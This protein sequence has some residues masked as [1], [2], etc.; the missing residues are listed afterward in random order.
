MSNGVSSIP[1]LDDECFSA[2]GG[3]KLKTIKFVNSIEKT[4]LLF[5][6]IKKHISK[7]LICFLP[8]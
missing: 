4:D 5:Q 6:F 2:V 7:D 1:I 8:T 3:K